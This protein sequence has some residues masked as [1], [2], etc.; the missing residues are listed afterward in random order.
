M[1]K[2]PAIN[3]VRLFLAAGCTLALASVPA[4]AQNYKVVSARELAQNSSRYVSQPVELRYGYCSQSTVSDGYECTTTEALIIRADRVSGSGKKA[5][6]EACGEM[7]TL[8]QSESCRFKLQFVPTGISSEQGQI[9][10]NREM[11]KARLT[12]IHIQ[13]MIVSR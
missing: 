1:V 8:I 10:R 5:L 7:D 4:A 3:R 9:P 11:I 2:E 13:T 6:D 12:I